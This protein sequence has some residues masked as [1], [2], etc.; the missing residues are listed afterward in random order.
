MNILQ[1]YPSSKLLYIHSSVHRKKR[2]N[3]AALADTL[4]SELSPDLQ[5]AMDLTQER[6]PLAG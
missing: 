6:V 1:R 5:R 4:R 2:E 3:M